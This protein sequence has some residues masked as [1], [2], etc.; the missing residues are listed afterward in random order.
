VELLGDSGVRL[1]SA[2]DIG[3]KDAIDPSSKNSGNPIRMGAEQSSVTG[4]SYS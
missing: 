3:G 4:S 2:E 1:V